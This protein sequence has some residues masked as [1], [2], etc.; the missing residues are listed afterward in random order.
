MTETEL[1]R[2]IGEKIVND[3]A[4]EHFAEKTRARRHRIETVRH[5]DRLLRIINYGGY[6]PNRGYIDFGYDGK[7]LL[8]SVKHIK[9]PK[10]SACQRC[11]K[12]LTSRRMRKS[13]DIPSKGN[14]YRRLLDYMWTLY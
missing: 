12:R 7:A 2:Q 9:Y 10:N 5:T 13:R 14:Y 8:H 6:A 1:N 3:T 11:L 4:E